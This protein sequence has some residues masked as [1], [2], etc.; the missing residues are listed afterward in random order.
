MLLAWISRYRALNHYCKDRAPW[1]ELR[2][3]AFRES[4]PDSISDP[5]LL[6]MTRVTSMSVDWTASRSRIPTWFETLLGQIFLSYVFRRRCARGAG[7]NRNFDGYGQPS[8]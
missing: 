1:K 3:P 2:M 8:N 4:W 6:R 5:S 7:G